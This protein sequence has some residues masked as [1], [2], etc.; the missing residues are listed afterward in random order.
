MVCRRSSLIPI[1]CTM[2][3]PRAF[4]SDIPI[5]AK[6]A[7]A[8]PS[9]DGYFEPDAS[10]AKTW[11]TV[12]EQSLH[13]AWEVF[14]VTNSARFDTSAVSSLGGLNIQVTSGA[15]FGIYSSTLVQS[16]KQQ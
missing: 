5:P 11:K 9:A 15:G 1:P 6:K 13:F 3:S 8:M 2:G 7:A 10:R 16:R 4:L 12:H 14:N